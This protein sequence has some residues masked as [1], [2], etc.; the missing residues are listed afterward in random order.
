M[1]KTISGI[2]QIGIGV[3]NVHEAWA[4]YH[5]HFGMDVRIFEDDT[6]AEL[7]LPYTGGKPQRRHAALAINLQ[8]GSGFEIWQYTER[9]PQPPAFDIALGDLGLFAAKM[10]SHDVPAA[11]AKM[12][13]EG[14]NLLG[15]IQKDPAGNPFYFVKDPYG[16]IFQVVQDHVIFRRKE[17]KTTGASVGAIVGVSDIEKSL[18]VYRDILKYDSVIYDVEGEMSDLH[19]VNGGKGKFRRVLLKATDSHQGSFN[20]LLGNSYIELIQALDHEPR[21]IYEN[22]FWGDLGFIHLCFDVR[23]MNK[24]KKECEAKG[25]AF[26][27]D[28]Q[29][30]EAHQKSFDMGEAAGHF[31]YIEDPDGTLIEFVETHKVPIVKKLG[32]FLNLQNRKPTKPVPSWVIKA[33]RFNRIKP[34]S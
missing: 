10:K 14:V 8:G 2:Q 13:S 34:K 30:N 18:L 11:Y 22:R 31:S 28:S 4:W 23:G 3:P 5:E 27:V 24:L 15:N 25:F 6:V 26:T 12:K 33:L 1:E 21:K 7:M 29:Q 20:A 17:K 19:D 16:N 9:T 32:W